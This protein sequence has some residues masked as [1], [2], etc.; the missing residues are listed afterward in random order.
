[1]NADGSGL[2]PRLTTVLGT[3][4]PSGWSADGSKIYFHSTRTG[5]NPQ[6]W[7]M[8]ADGGNQTNLV[9]ERGLEEHHHGPDLLDPSS[10]AAPRRLAVAGC[11][12]AASGGPRGLLRGGA[13]NDAICT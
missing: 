6:I 13:P 1:M 7:S 8:N 11:V 9:A 5:N 12:R 2:S 4:R 3:D 10:G